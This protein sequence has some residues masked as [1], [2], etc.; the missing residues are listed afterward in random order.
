MVHHPPLLTAKNFSV[1][2][3]SEVTNIGVSTIAQD[4][5]VSPGTSLPPTAGANALIVLGAPHSADAVADTAKLHLT[6][7]YNNARDQTPPIARTTNS[8]ARPCPAVSTTIRLAWD[9]TVR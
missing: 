2:A 1:L 6:G 9:S 8:G 4:L 5:G 7:A 3:G